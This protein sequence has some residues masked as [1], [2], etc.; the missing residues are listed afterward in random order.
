MNA[1][2]VAS[3]Y[4]FY[5]VFVLF[6]CVMF[7]VKH[8]AADY[9]LQTS[10]MLG[11]FKGGVAWI[12]PLTA[13]CLVHALMTTAIAVVFFGISKW[14]VGVLDFVIHFIMDR[15]KAGPRWLGRF[16]ALSAKEYVALRSSPTVTQGELAEALK[17]NTW[18]WRSLGIDQFVHHLTHY[19]ILYILLK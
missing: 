16:K 9:F 19:L 15:I 17:S 14:W 3:P 1:M 7:Q 11:K 13:H 6:W 8:L 2:I 10:W 5:L 18:F 12:L 4:N